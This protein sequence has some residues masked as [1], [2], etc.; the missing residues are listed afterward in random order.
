MEI[1]ILKRRFLFFTSSQ[2]LKNWFWKQNNKSDNKVLD[3]A[4]IQAKTQQPK[5]AY[6]SPLEAYTS[7]ME[8]Y[9]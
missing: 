8:P 7:L 4:Q 9:A 1:H 5:Q 3:N 2:Q 6:I